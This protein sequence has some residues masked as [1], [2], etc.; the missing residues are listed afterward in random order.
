MGTT[1]SPPIAQIVP[2]IAIDGVKWSQIVAKPLTSND[3]TRVKPKN[4]ELSFFWANCVAGDP[5]G[6][7]VDQLL[8][9]GFHVATPVEC[10]V[11]GLKPNEN[12]WRY[13]DLLLLT[14]AKSDYLGAL[15]YNEQ[16]SRERLRPEIAAK[17]GMMKESQGM[18]TKMFRQNKLAF[19]QPTQ[20]ERDARFNK[21][22]Q[23]AKP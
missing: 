17:R 4:N 5:K 14:I 11:P 8:A 3:F 22:V 7:R 6:S 10:E 12:K 9:A 2:E 19:V 23:E 16:V 18:T 21:A 13:G 20:E 15:K 1:I